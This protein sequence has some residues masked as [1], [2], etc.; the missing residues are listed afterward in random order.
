ML[1]AVS[2]F[3]TALSCACCLRARGPCACFPAHREEV[4]GII[5]MQLRQ[6][7]AEIPTDISNL[8]GAWNMAKSFCWRENV[9]VPGLSDPR[10]AT[11]A[12]GARLRRVSAHRHTHSSSGSSTHGWVLIGDSLVLG[13]G[14]AQGLPPRCWL[15]AVRGAS[16]PS[17]K[18]P[19]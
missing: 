17:K 7:G 14:R 11:P 16:T 6:V 2:I 19:T 15:M 4:D 1:F 12:R 3:L 13:C 10:H 5:L 18:A 8:K 9:N